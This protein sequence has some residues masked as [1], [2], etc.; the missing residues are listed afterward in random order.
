MSDSKCSPDQAIAAVGYLRHSFGGWL[1]PD[2][3]ERAHLRMFLNFTPGR[4]SQPSRPCC[5]PRPVDSR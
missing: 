5:R 3:E 1:I 2:Q 4:S